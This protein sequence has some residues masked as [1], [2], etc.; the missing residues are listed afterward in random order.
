MQ[1]ATQSAQFSRSTVEV[2]K[3][4]V[5]FKKS[6][7]SLYFQKIRIRV[8]LSSPTTPQ[9]LPESSDIIS[10]MVLCCGGPINSN[11]RPRTNKFN[12]GQP[13][14]GSEMGLC[15]GFPIV[16]IVQY[17]IVK[18]PIVQYCIVRESSQGTISEPRTGCPKLKL[19]VLGRQ[20]E[21]IEPPQHRIIVVMM[22]GDYGNHCGVVGES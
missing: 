12:F 21:L 2:G 17:C 9:W 6:Q 14:R 16:S 18:N 8:V 22:S 7:F 13:V 19:F 3:T 1:N 20:L 4:W 11:W 5:L 15:K 10:T